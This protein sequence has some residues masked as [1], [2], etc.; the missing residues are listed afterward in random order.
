MTSTSETSLILKMLDSA[1]D[2]TRDLGHSLQRAVR[3]YSLKEEDDKLVEDEEKVE[4]TT[5]LRVLGAPIGLTR[6]CN[7]FLEKAKNCSPA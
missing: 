7:K 3:K 5:G 6:Y 1:D 4:V 2:T